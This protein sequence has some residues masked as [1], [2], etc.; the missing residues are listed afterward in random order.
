M[1]SKKES[2]IKYKIL[3]TLIVL[4]I[5]TLGKSIPLYM[6][7][8]TVYMDKSINTDDLLIQTISGD[9]YQC[10][11]LA[12]GISPYMIS[13]LLVQIVSLFFKADKRSKL[14]PKK[15]AKISLAITFIIA[16]IQAAIKV[17]D[18]QFSVT[19]NML[20]LARM[21]SFAEM[22]TG[23]MII[24]WLT[25]RCK[26][27][28]LGGQ[29]VLILAN[30]IDSIRVMTADYDIEVL[31]IPLLISFFAMIITIIMDNAEKRIPVQRISIHNIYADKNYMAIKLNPIGVMPAMFSTAF[32]LLPQL[33]LAL[34]LKIFPDNAEI[35]WCTN[36]MSLEKPLGI[37]T[38]VVILYMLSIIFSRAFINPRDITEQYLK[39]GDS[40]VNLHAGRET[41]KYLSKSINHISFAS[42]TIMSVCLLLP[43]VLNVYGYIG[44]KLIALPSMTMMITGLWCNLYREYTA[45]KN[46]Q[47][48]KPFI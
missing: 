46:L 27:F 2:I 37:A 42:A 29:S 3:Y 4:I 9:I 44:S 10:S 34:L 23:A 24:V 12:L 43:I 45:V 22:I 33:A 28:G 8:M 21:I 39:S 40:I 16:A 41:R 47:A 20:N 18:L 5:Y 19:G 48:Y 11:V 35:I 31:K 7:D 15:M 1:H 32:F 13:S 36:N 17:S 25:G 26:R 6:V 30:V 38:Y 14:S